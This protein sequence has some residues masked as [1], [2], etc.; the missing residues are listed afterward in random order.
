MAETAVRDIPLRGSTLRRN[1]N[2]AVRRG[3]NRRAGRV[4]DAPAAVAPAPAV[5]NGLTLDALDAVI[6]QL[7]ATGVTGEA[8]LVAHV[9]PSPFALDVESNVVAI[10]A[11]VPAPETE[12][13]VAE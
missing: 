5:V 6:A 12:T 13:E 8:P 4:A 7:R 11:V 9:H 10:H 3:R 1:E 2:L